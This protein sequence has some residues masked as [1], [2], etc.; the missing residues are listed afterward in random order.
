MGTRRTADIVFC[1][2]SSASMRPCFDQ[3]RQHIGSL[4][5]GLMSD[6]QGSWDLRFDFV[7]YKATRSGEATVYWM[8]SLRNEIAVEALY[9]Q[10][11]GPGAF[12]TNDVQEFRLGL[13]KLKAGG[14]EASFVALDTALDF[15]WR[16]ATAAHRVIILLT[17]EALET[18]LEVTL[19]KQAIP[20]LIEKVH[21]LRIALHLVGPSSGGFDQICGADKSEY[22]V[23]DDAEQGLANVDFSKTLAGIGKSISASTLQ[24]VSARAGVRRAIFGQDKWGRMGAVIQGA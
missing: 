6:G 15:P 14:D 20:D 22:A 13:S 1:L 5:S 19:Q 4:V 12:F 18:G 9:G 2:D 21:A 8:Q 23:V 10:K 3:V 7:A 16:D 11:A 24:S 17:D